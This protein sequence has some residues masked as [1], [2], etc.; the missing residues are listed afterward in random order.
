MEFLLE[1]DFVQ[2]E[3]WRE[4]RDGAYL[5][6]AGEGCILFAEAKNFSL[7]EV[8][9]D[10]GTVVPIVVGL[11]VFPF[12]VLPDFVVFKPVVKELI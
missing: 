9:G 10:L 3:G 5:T 12:A 8:G 4:H 11:E 7:F 6:V 1:R 2:F